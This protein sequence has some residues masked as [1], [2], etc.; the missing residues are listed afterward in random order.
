MII[1]MNNIL[2]AITTF[3]RNKALLSLLKDLVNINLTFDIVIF[4]NSKDDLIDLKFFKENFNI[5]NLKIRINNSNLQTLDYSEIDKYSMAINSRTRNKKKTIFIFSNGYNIGGSGGIGATQ[6]LFNSM[7]KYDYLW[8]LD[9]EVKIN[10]NTLSELIKVMRRERDIGIVG[11]VIMKDNDTILEAGSLMNRQKFEFIPQLN[12]RKLRE[13][14]DVPKVDYVSAASMLISKE[15]VKKIDVFRNYFIH[16][17]D[18]EYCFRAKKH[19][20]KVRIAMNST[21]QNKVVRKSSYSVHDLRNYLF[22]AKEYF[23]NKDKVILFK[24][25]LKDLIYSIIYDKQSFKVL[26]RS[27][28]YFIISKYGII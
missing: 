14:I 26:S 2:V 25:I 28:Y 13:V 9:D 20:F 12:S 24:N 17:D 6:Y 1:R 11:S 4:N 27:V 22:L 3:N 10:K 16:V 8:L 21:I 23:S 5:I 18:A 7:D 19:G 15:C